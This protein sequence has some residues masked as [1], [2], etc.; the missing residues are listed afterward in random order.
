VQG[1]GVKK[2]G[3]REMISQTK[4]SINRMMQILHNITPLYG[5]CSLQHHRYRNPWNQEPNYSVPLSFLLRHRNLFMILQFLHFQYDFACSLCISTTPAWAG[6]D[7]PY[8]PV[9]GWRVTW[10]WLVPGWSYY[11][12]EG[13]LQLT[14]EPNGVGNSSFNIRLNTLFPWLTTR[15][16]LSIWASWCYNPQDFTDQAGVELVQPDVKLRTLMFRVQ[17]MIEHFTAVTMRNIQGLFCHSKGQVVL[18]VLHCS[19]VVALW[20][21]SEIQNQHMNEKY[22]NWLYS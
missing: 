11:V 15:R 14:V 12:K 1:K 9:L 2:C 6:W 4:R 16:Q 3:R 7:L 17:N 13:L 22:T 10:F 18:H 20:L 5:D 21:E 8:A 19:S